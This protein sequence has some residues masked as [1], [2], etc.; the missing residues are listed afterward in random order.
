MAIEFSNSN[1]QLV[2]FATSYT[3]GTNTSMCAWLYLD[4]LTSDGGAVVL[5]HDGGSEYLALV[6]AGSANANQIVFSSGHSTTPGNWSV[7]QAES[8]LA[9]GL[10]FHLCATYINTGDPII[11]VN[12]VSK[13]VIE[14]QTPVGTAPAWASGSARVGGWS[15]MTANLYSLDGKIAD[16]RIYNRIL[17]AAEVLSIASSRCMSDN[18]YGLVFHAPFT[19]AAGLTA[20]DGVA[21]AAGNTV[22][23]RI[24]G[25]IGTP[26]VSPIG[27]AETYI[28]C[29]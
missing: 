27:R 13:V 4:A 22:R 12:G 18:D 6:Y 7:S 11:Y 28:A 9:T 2:E 1:L 23:D 10:W 17:T 29:P 14:D 16:A 20:Y 15:G 24:S 5:E 21:L 26:A 25:A 19:G 3:V 8:G